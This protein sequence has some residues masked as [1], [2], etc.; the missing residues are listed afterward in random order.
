[1][2]RFIIILLALISFGAYGQK[3]DISGVTWYSQD[4]YTSA[5]SFTL[6][7]ESWVTSFQPGDSMEIRDVV[8]G[9][10]EVT[11]VPIT[12]YMV[13]VSFRKRLD[14]T[15]NTFR[16]RFIRPSATPAV[17]SR[18]SIQY[19]NW[20]TSLPANIRYLE[21]NPGDRSLGLNIDL[22][23]R[24]VD[25]VEVLI[26]HRI[27]ATWYS[28]DIV[29]Q[30]QDRRVFHDVSPGTAIVTIRGIN[31]D[32]QYEIYWTQMVLIN[33]DPNEGSYDAVINV[34][35]FGKDATHLDLFKVYAL[36]DYDWM[37]EPKKIVVLPY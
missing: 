2:K 16:L 6:V 25:R 28:D 27:R 35:E 8:V 26:N 29:G 18:A 17:Q 13:R 12:D 15:Q 7:L 14:S 1:M 3:P 22:E 19:T 9:S 11:T 37:L 23:Y 31:Y 36:I 30:I 21:L 5:D 34:S 32:G 20:C 4:C 33:S 24:L 10:V